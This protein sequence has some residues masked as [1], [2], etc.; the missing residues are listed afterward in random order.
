MNHQDTD[1][2]RLRRSAAY[3]LLE[4]MLA[5]ALLGALM[6][7]AWS[8]MGTFSSAEQR[9]WKLAHRIQTIRAARE[10]LQTDVQQLVQSEPISTNSISKKS[11]LSGNSL[12]FTALIAPSIDPLPFLENVMS[13]SSD[14]PGATTNANTELEP[15]ASLYSDSDAIVAQAQQ[16]LW[17]AETLEVE[18]KLAPDESSNSAGSSSSLVADLS[19]VQFSLT[20]R[21]MMDATAAIN[22]PSSPTRAQPTNNLADRVLTAQDLYRQTDE[23]TQSSGLAIRETRL[24]G[25]T[26]VQ[27]Q[28]FDGASWKRE[29]NSDQ[30]GGLPRAIALC[31][32]FPARANMKPPEPK[33]TGSDSGSSDPSDLLASIPLGTDMAFADSA[34]AAEPTAETSSGSESSLMQSPTHEVQ[35]VVY[36]GGQSKRPNGN[37]SFGSPRNTSAGGGFE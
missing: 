3:T 37:Q 15:A 19:E 4:L 13:S 24:E 22:N 33:T 20:R 21:E 17:P 30:V 14:G 10:W 12:G 26:N 32:D 27:F 11:R 25:L 2:V 9:G 16:S 31:F 5:L 23:T 8:L 34:L 28:Y 18:Y 1:R 6:T 7:V 29:W 35:I 36:V